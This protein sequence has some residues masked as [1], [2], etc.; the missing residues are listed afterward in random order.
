M[1]ACTSNILQA[2]QHMLYTIVHRYKYLMFQWTNYNYVP[3]VNLYLLCLCTCM[4]SEAQ[5][6]GIDWGGPNPGDLDTTVTV[7]ET[8]CPLMACEMQE[9]QSAVAPLSFSNE[10]GM[11]SYERTLDFVASKL[12]IVL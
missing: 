10:Y 9:L 7:P 12:D 1:F 3:C 5:H 4:Q 11:D 6:Y 8:I 2:A